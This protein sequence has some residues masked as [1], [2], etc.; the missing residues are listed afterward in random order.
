METTTANDVPAEYETWRA[1]RWAEL[2][3][4][5][6][7]AKVVAKAVISG[8]GPTAIPGVPGQWGT[9][10][11]GALTVTATAADGVRVGDRAVD[12]TVEVPSGGPIGFAGP[13]T[14]F[15]GGG[16]GA[17][18]LVV[19]D[20]RAPARSGLS[21]IDAYPYDPAWVH[22]GEYR[23]APAGRSVEVER[24][25]SPRSTGSIAAPVDLAVIIDGIEYLFTVLEEQPGQRLVV[26]TDDTSGDGTP[27]IGRWLRLPPREPGSRLIVDFNR[28]TLSHHHLAPAVFTCPLAPPGNHLPLRVEAGERALTYDHPLDDTG[29]RTS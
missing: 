5:N 10:A 24:L 4:P 27:A 29:S 7:R 18:S 22:E 13:R 2:T 1:A 15:A 6:G 12:G 16:S 11:S 25:T 19:F 28:A 17:Y 26:F 8:P 20:D 9:T 14:G 23:A 21:G 3:G